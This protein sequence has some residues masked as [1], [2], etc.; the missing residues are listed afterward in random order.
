MKACARDAETALRPRFLVDAASAELLHIRP[1]VVSRVRRAL[2][3]SEQALFPA[4]AFQSACAPVNAI[5]FALLRECASIA[6]SGFSAD[7]AVALALERALGDR[8]RAVR[9]E[10]RTQGSLDFPRDFPELLSRFDQAEAAA[11]LA[12]LVQ[13]YLAGETMGRR[14]RP[15]LDLDGDLR[16]TR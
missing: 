6:G 9:R 10:I 8:V 1:A 15:K 14:K 3:A 16:G 11:D 4:G 7:E 5:E 13:R 2:E 12:G